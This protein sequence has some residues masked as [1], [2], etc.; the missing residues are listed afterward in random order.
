[1]LCVREFC[2]QEKVMCVGE[3]VGG[4]CCVHRG[5]G[6]ALSVLW[7]CQCVVF[8]WPSGLCVHLS[9]VVLRE[10]Y[11]LMCCICLHFVCLAG[12]AVCFVSENGLCVCVMPVAGGALWIPPECG[13]GNACVACVLLRSV[14]MCEGVGTGPER[15]CP[16]AVYVWGVSGVCGVCRRG[17]RGSE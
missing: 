15:V 12:S 10:L 11:L 2:A 16:C 7:V 13:S 8:V 9:L 5:I 6:C 4:E 1:M 14:Y 17:P 3:Y